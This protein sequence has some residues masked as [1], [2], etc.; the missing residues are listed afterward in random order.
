MV[1]EILTA[2]TE[3]RVLGQGCLDEAHGTPLLQSGIMV[4]TRFLT[5]D[6]D[7]T[8]LLRVS[9]KGSVT[10]EKLKREHTDGPAVNL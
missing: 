6:A 8:F 3:V 2:G 7:A 4:V 9:F 5:Q 1:Q 10:Y